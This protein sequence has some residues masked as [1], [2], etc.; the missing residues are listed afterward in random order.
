MRKKEKTEHI[1]FTERWKRTF[2]YEEKV[3]KEQI[4]K[5]IQ[6]EFSPNKFFNKNFLRKQNRRMIMK[7]FFFLK[8][9]PKLKKHQKNISFE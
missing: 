8:K 6:E 1:Y 4:R 3:D 2:F 7:A 5:D 9:N